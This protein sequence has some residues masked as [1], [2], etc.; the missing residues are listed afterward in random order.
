VKILLSLDKELK[1]IYSKLNKN[2]YSINLEYFR[3]SFGIYI[4]ITTKNLSF[5]GELPNGLFRPMV[6]T[7]ANLFN[8]W[9]ST[10]ILIMLYYASLTLAVAII[11]GL[12]T[13]LS[14]FGIG[15][16]GLVNA[17]FFYGFG[18]IDH[19]I[20]IALLPFVLAFSNCG[21]SLALVPDKKIKSEN[22]ALTVYSVFIVFGF[23][24]AGYEKALNWID[25]DLNTSGFLSW[26]YQGYYSYDRTKLLAS[27]VTSFHPL[28]TEAMDYL[29]V[30]FE[31]TGVFFLVF[32]RRSWILY[33]I[34]AGLF[35]LA[36]TV[37]LNIPFSSHLMVFGL[38][39]I[40]PFMKKHYFLVLIFPLLC[41]RGDIYLATI[42]WI[43][44]LILGFLY[45][46]TSKEKLK[47]R[48]LSALKN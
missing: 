31:I 1:G 33:L 30:L 11:L 28:I 18:K 10:T 9:P 46:L 29:A 24:T 15:I 40:S 13:R 6:L 3:I 41:F 19:S 17:S 7:F 39:I 32:S 5:L 37:L 23:F 27:A 22:I 43:I 12:K 34:I 48:L 25:F 47:Y 14:L 44:Y 21:T 38:W 16:L 2:T 36:N 35:H 42:G 45:L 4:L 20:M 8:S 26:F